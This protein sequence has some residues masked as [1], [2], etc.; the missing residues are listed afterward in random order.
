[1][2]MLSKTYIPR[3]IMVH[4]PTQQC[5][6]GSNGIVIVYHLLYES[7]WSGVCYSIREGGIVHIQAGE[8]NVNC[9]CY[10]QL[11]LRPCYQMFQQIVVRFQCRIWDLRKSPEAV[12]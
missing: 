5:V 1:M 6:K 8:P 12:V 2:L 11:V 3:S 10:F 9:P 7:P 4:L